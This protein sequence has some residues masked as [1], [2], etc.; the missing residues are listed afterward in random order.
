MDFEQ[1]VD[2]IINL[3]HRSDIKGLDRMRRFMGLLGNP[4]DKLSYIHITGTNGKGST[5][6]MLNSILTCAGY[7]AGMFVSPYVL[8]FR[9]R[10]Q[11]GGKMIPKE[12]L[13][14]IVK[15]IKP[16][17]DRMY[18]EGDGPVQFEVVTA[19]GFVYFAEQNCDIVCLEVGIGGLRDSTNIIQ[20]PLA[21]VIANIGLDHTNML[22][23]TLE[24]IA[25]QKAGIIKG[26]CPV[27]V[28]PAEDPGA[29]AVIMEK[30]AENGNTLIQ[31][32]FN[33]ADIIQNGLD[34]TIFTYDGLKLRLPLLGRHQVCNAINVIETIHA[35]R[36]AGFQITDAQIVQGIADVKFPA[37]AEILCRH[38]LTILDGAHNDNGAEALENTLKDVLKGINPLVLIMG[39]MG[40][41]DC[42]KVVKRLASLADAVIA[43]TP[44]LEYRALPKEKLAEI[45][46]ESCKCVE[47][48]DGFRES[49]LRASELAGEKG[50]VVI[51]GSLYLASDM[52]DAILELLEENPCFQRP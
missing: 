8:E 43:V 51:C 23:N 1:T 24:A 14:R 42:R 32:N 11:I 12:E 9:E 19:I 49:W 44:S 29:L 36:G 26:K 21:A 47:L 28:Y 30:C 15:E 41:K 17:I 46:G 22:G 52:R 18:E 39:M 7:K 48:G 6:A 20:E 4:Q 25:A 27:C 33:H 35:V 16:V 40:D 45:A 13:V 3:R 34:G 10:I 37:R 50:A 5:T 38:P 2:Y 31:G